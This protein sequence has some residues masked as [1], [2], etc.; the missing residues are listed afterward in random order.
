MCV[1]VCLCGEG[2]VYLQLAR[3]GDTSAFSLDSMQRL[4]SVG[5]SG[6]SAAASRLS[7]N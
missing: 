2:G 5:E 4:T 7:A 3:C 6:G 1:C